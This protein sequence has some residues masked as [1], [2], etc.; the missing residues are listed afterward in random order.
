MSYREELQA[1]LI[2]W[3]KHRIEKSRSE[4][5][6]GV[7]GVAPNEP[8]DPAD[9]LDFNEEE[10]LTDKGVRQLHEALCREAG[11]TSEQIIAAWNEKCPEDPW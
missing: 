8:L 1:L 5:L 11:F 2:E 10:G 3:L 7:A 6:A 9:Q 4:K